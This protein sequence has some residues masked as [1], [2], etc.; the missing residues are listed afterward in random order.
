MAIKDWFKNMFNNPWKKYAVITGLIIASVVS[1]IVVINDSTKKNKEIEE[2]IPAVKVVRDSLVIVHE[3]LSD[4][5]AYLNAA[6]PDSALQVL[7][8]V[9][10]ILDKKK[11]NNKLLD[12]LV[13]AGIIEDKDKDLVKQIRQRSANLRKDVQ[14]QFAKIGR[15]FE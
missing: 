6:N 4:V 3:K 14:K 7:E 13:V 9:D 15:G 1:T 8:E 10:D 12:S 11:L 2:K 5:Q